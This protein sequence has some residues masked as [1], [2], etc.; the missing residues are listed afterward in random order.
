M[1]GSPAKK[2]VTEQRLHSRSASLPQLFHT[3]PSGRRL[4]RAI[5]GFAVVAAVAVPFAQ[6]P[7]LGSTYRVFLK[8]GDALPSY[9]EAAVV[10]DRIV[11][12]LS[13]G[14]SD[15][16]LTLQLIS[17]PLPLVDLD[18]TTR[19]AEAMRAAFFA[20]TRGEAEYGA[21]TAALSRDLEALSE[22]TDRRRQLVLA[23]ELRERL[24]A[25]PR[26]RFNY[27]ADDVEKLA[28][29]VGDVV[30]EL[31]A[32]V[33]EK[34]VELELTAGPPSSTREP[35]L[36]SPRRREAIQLSLSASSAADN[37]EDRL[38][39]LRAASAVVPPDDRDLANVVARRLDEEVRAGVSYAALSAEIR[40]RAR[41]AVETGDPRTV[42]RLETEL[43]GRDQ[44]LGF[45]RPQLVQ[46]LVDEIRAARDA[47]TARREVLDKYAAVRRRLLAY[48]L[49]VRPAFSA[50]DGLRSVLQYFR[51]MRSVS[52]E[53]TVETY[54]RFDRLRVQVEGVEP[55]VE[56]S[57]VHATLVSAMR[58]AVE[59]AARRREAA[60]TNALPALRAASSAA[61]GALLLGDRA[62]ADL[63]DSLCLGGRVTTCG[64]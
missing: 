15:G 32:A 52:F 49:Q 35:L 33:G 55:P 48:E 43:L 29:L 34:T 60:A 18:R 27:R 11:F 42:E 9:G 57:G 10:A 22:V 30:N 19:Y 24:V 47:A 51:D 4:L 13:I 26:T 58:M 50:L 21:M 45:R 53:R 64:P 3:K 23:E 14:G 39:V 25:W 28:G 54:D 20:A 56:V 62:R 63:V 6:A 59:A 31:K 36:P 16:P 8:N 7:E 1:F 40:K 61:A 5:V 2:N 44:Q 46:G 37:G 41:A 12:N 38:A 17:L